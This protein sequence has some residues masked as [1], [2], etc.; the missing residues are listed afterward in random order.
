MISLARHIETLLLRHDCVVVPGFGG[1]I[2][3][4]AEALPEQHEA[5]TVVYPPYR[6]VRFN[7]SL[8][9]NDGLLVGSYMKVYDAAFPAAEAQMRKDINL[10]VDGLRLNGAYE[11]GNIGTLHMDVHHH[12]TLDTHESGIATPAF[13]GLS[14]LQLKSAETLEAE[15][16]LKEAIELTTLAPVVTAPA[17]EENDRGSVTLTIRR[18]WIDIAI[19]AA[20]AVVLFFLVSYP[21]LREPATSDVAVAALGRSNSEQ[22]STETLT[23]TAS[24]KPSKDEVKV[25]Q[26]ERSLAQQASIVPSV[27]DNANANALPYTLVLASYVAEP[28]A[29]DYVENLAKAGLKEARFERTGKVSHVFYAHYSTEEEANAALK[30]LREQSK[31]F[32][33]AWVYHYE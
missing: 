2:T 15:R 28:N 27:K 8:T 30:Q 23:S 29:L 4:Y 16:Q 31:E 24:Y 19:S 33:E 17:D 5:L 22:V 6:V 13:Y 9:Q 11:L 18:R 32:S 10:M 25:T 1:F 14:N 3:N 21:M 20:A 7:E 12:V 26:T